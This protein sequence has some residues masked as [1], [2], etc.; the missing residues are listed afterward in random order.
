V[1]GYCSNVPLDRT[2]STLGEAGSEWTR[3]LEG[4]TFSMTDKEK[5]AYKDW[6]R[7]TIDVTSSADG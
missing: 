4:S 2:G 1:K 6:E 3:F 5:F 7:L